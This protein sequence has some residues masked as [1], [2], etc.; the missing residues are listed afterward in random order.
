[1]NLRMQ[2]INELLKHEIGNLILKEFDFN[3]D[4]MITITEVNTSPDLHQARIKISTLPFLKTEK[5]IKVLNSQTTTLQKLLGQ[6]L[7]MKIIPKIKFEPDQ[8]EEKVNR[9]D[10]LLKKIK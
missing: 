6:K 1:M 2:K 8:S 10:Q 7:K 5:I 3:R 4:T 9:V